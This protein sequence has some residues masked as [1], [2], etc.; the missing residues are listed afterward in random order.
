MTVFGTDDTESGA[1]FEAEVGTED[2]VEVPVVL[3]ADTA[4]PDVCVLNNPAVGLDV[5]ICVTFSD[6]VE[7][8][9]KSACE[10]VA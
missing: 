4:A 1:E 10:E 5:T 2:N 7:L 9:V 3:T 6:K 8:S